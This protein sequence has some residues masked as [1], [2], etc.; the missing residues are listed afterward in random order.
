MRARATPPRSLEDLPPT[1]QR[2]LKRILQLIFKSL[3]AWQRTKLLARKKE[4]RI[5]KVILFGSQARGDAVE[6]R[7]SGYFSDY[8]ILI[9]VDDEVLTDFEVW[10]KA[11]DQ[12]FQEYLAKSLRRTVTLIVHTLHDVNDQLARGRYFWMDVARDGIPLYESNGNRRFVT[13]TELDPRVAHEEAVGYFED[14]LVSSRRL[15]VSAHALIKASGSKD[16]AFILHQSAERAYAALLLTLTLYLPAIHDLKKLHE[17]AVALD[18][19][20]YAVWGEDKKPFGRG[21][22]FGKRCFELLRDAY[23]KARYSRH[24][25][26][27]NEELTLLV[28]RVTELQAVVETVC[29]ERLDMLS[30]QV[31]G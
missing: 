19:R 22:R 3:H 30:K 18:P 15:L 9:V 31:G 24:Y 2:E 10:E 8:D 20:L 21:G 26:I 4:A 14:N 5:L 6:D 27:T 16:A 12:L 28:E 29:R 7:S 25:R 11:D 23:V 1:R 17:R 13:P